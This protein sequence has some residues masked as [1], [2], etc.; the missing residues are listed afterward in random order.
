ML[1]LPN[2]N[3]PSYV[4]LS[5]VMLILE[6]RAAKAHFHRAT[7]QFTKPQSNT[8]TYDPDN[9]GYP[10]VVVLLVSGVSARGAPVCRQA[11]QEAHRAL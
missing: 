6:G 10:S 11:S 5:V 8:N 1:T 3:S 7:V 2:D 4:L 9:Y